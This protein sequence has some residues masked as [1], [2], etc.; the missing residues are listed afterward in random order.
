MTIKHFI[1]ID[2]AFL[3]VEN[4]CYERIRHPHYVLPCSQIFRTRKAANHRIQQLCDTLK[5]PAG[6]KFL[7][8][9]QINA[10]QQEE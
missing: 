10:P 5:Y 6:R 2:A 8:V 7:Q 1:I 3:N 4:L 9:V